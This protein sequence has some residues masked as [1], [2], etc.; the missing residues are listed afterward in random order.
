MILDNRPYHKKALLITLLVSKCS[1][2]FLG[3]CFITSESAAS[4]PNPN[5]GNISVPKST[6]K[7]CITVIGNGIKPPENRNKIDGNASGTLEVKM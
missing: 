2:R 3:A 4:A 7:I 5:A 1:L 6:V